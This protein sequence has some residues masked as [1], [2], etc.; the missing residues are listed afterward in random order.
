MDQQRFLS[1]HTGRCVSCGQDDTLDAMLR[2]EG[3]ANG[4][5]ECKDCHVEKFQDTDLWLYGELHALTTS[6]V[7]NTKLDNTLNQNKIRRLF[8]WCFG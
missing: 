1:T 4:L 2:K 3:A 6:V 5:Y 7:P 8:S